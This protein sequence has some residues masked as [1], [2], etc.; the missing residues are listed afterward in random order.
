MAVPGC[1]VKRPTGLLTA[2]RPCPRWHLQAGDA[3]VPLCMRPCVSQRGVGGLSH[4]YL[5]QCC[6]VSTHGAGKCVPGASGPDMGAGEP[7]VEP[8]GGDVGLGSQPPR[9]KDKLP[10]RSTTACRHGKAMV[11]GTTGSD[12]HSLTAFG[13]GGVATWAGLGSPRPRAYLGQV[14]GPQGAESASLP[15]VPLVLAA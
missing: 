2:P 6:S 13:T 7:E 9:H 4:T 14:E 8:T 15:W 1:P 3:A 5:L 10:N 12:V 11:R